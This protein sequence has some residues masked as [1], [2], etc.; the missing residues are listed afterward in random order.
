[1]ECVRQGRKFTIPDPNL[2][3]R[4][5]VSLMV[6][7]VTADRLQQ[8]FHT[9]FAGDL[10]YLQGDTAPRARAA[11]QS[12]RCLCVAPEVSRRIRLEDRHDG[13]II[14][15]TREDFRRS[16]PLMGPRDAL[17]FHDVAPARLALAVRLALAG[18]S[19]FPSELVP[20]KDVA[21]PVLEG[22]EQ[23]SEADRAVMAEL[24]FGLDDQQIAERLGHA[25]EGV[26]QSVERIFRKLGC[27]SRTEVAL[28]AYG[29]LSPFLDLRQTRPG[30]VRERSSRN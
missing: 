6:D 15:V 19:V 3:G 4:I 27:R 28:L 10:L 11:E 18:M 8:A 12:R 29:R 14:V 30:P 2:Q 1:M 16:P 23:L 17:L 9:A 24:A 25:P 7:G 5:T 22:F 21:G 20:E 13:L 26:R